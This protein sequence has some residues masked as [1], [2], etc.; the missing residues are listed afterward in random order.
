MVPTYLYGSI[1]CSILSCCKKKSRFAGSQCELNNGAVI[2]M[3][4]AAALALPMDRSA[5]AGQHALVFEGC[6]GQFEAHPGRWCSQAF[7]RACVER[8]EHLPNTLC[9]P[10][11][12]SRLSELFNFVPR[13][14]GTP[15]NRGRLAGHPPMA[16]TFTAQR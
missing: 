2:T 6:N 7:R 13:N 8:L 11:Q 3:Q 12:D 5:F 10:C 15:H 16:N 9:M 14:Q 4:T 1:M